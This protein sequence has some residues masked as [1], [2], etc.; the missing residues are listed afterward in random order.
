MMRY[1]S[2]N[3]LVTSSIDG[4]SDR[5]FRT[6]QLSR[7]PKCLGGERDDSKANVSANAI[8]AFDYS[9]VNGSAEE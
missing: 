6:I 9:F 2:Q 8:V 1:L 3:I 4:S 7:R 5:Y